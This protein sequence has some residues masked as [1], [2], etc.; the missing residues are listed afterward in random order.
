MEAVARQFATGK[1]CL[2]VRNGWFSYRWTQ[3]FETGNIPS[4]CT[5]LKARRIAPGSKSPFAPC[6]IEEV[7]D[8]I[9]AEKPDVVI[10]PHVETSAGIILPNDYIK[11]MSDAVHSYGGLLILDCVAS[12]CIWVDMA[13][14]GVDVL[15]SAPQKGILHKH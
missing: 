2:V 3:I 15:I 7:V 13:Q 14:C 5:V 12:G 10:A 4:S 8:V 11:A 1:K 9:H 6:P